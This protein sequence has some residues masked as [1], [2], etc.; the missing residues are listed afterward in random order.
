MSDVISD[1]ML[2]IRCL[3]DTGAVSAGSV[4]FKGRELIKLTGL[5]E[6]EVDAADTY[7]LQAGFVEGTNGLDGSR[8]LTPSGVERFGK[9]KANRIPLSALAE[10]IARYVSEQS[11]DPASK[12][13][14]SNKIQSALVLDKLSYRKACQE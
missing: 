3:Y 2:I 6:S 9:E 7:L 14:D 13:I 4:D 12:A 1:A 5:S 8:W 10:R 11:S